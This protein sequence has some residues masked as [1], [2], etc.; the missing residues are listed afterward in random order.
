[1]VTED[2]G[3]RLSGFSFSVTADNYSLQHQQAGHAPAAVLHSY[4]DPHPPLWEDLAKVQNSPKVAPAPLPLMSMCLSMCTL[5]T[6]YVYPGSIR[7]PQTHTALPPPSAA[8]PLHG[9]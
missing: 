7:P 9:P 5:C 3:W 6:M 1:M 4:A 2:G 8:A